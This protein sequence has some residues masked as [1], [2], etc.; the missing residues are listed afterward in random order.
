MPWLGVPDCRVASP[1]SLVPG[2]GSRETSVSTSPSTR[3][4]VATGASARR[5]SSAEV[6]CIQALAKR[7][8]TP[9][10]ESGGAVGPDGTGLVVGID[11]RVMGAEAPEVVAPAVGAGVLE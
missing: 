7:P 6:R 11:P 4:A 1:A 9:A 8:T 5:R 2:G 10:T 3:L